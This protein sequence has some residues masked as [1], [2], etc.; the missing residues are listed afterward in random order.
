MERSG[1][2]CGAGRFGAQ[3]QRFDEEEEEEIDGLLE[4]ARGGG[5]GGGHEGFDSG[6]GPKD[7]GEATKDY[8]LILLCYTSALLQWS[9][10]N[11]DA[12]CVQPGNIDRVGNASI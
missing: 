1:C 3:G 7:K 2:G 11:N 10:K 4:G 8:D 6:D 12:A 5:E 9:D